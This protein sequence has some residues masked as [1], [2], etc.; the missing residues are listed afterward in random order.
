MSTSHLYKD[1][2]RMMNMRTSN[3]GTGT[4]MFE[5]ETR[6]PENSLLLLFCIGGDISVSF[7]PF[8]L[9]CQSLSSLTSK[10]IKQLL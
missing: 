9:H 6:P 5:D 4:R 1:Y 8:I 7:D 2:N 3:R 10:H